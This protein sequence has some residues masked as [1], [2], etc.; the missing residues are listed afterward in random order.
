MPPIERSDDS[1]IQPLLA[2]PC[3]DARAWPRCFPGQ[4]QRLDKGGGGRGAG[5]S[6]HAAS[7]GLC[8]TGISSAPLACNA[9]AVAVAQGWGCSQGS[10]P[11]R[12][13]AV[14]CAISHAAGLVAGTL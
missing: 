1:G 3:G 7:T 10:K 6:A 9:L 14:A 8:S 5:W 12:A 11:M 4:R 13:P 2:Q